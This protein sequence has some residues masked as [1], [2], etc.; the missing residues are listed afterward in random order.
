MHKTSHVYIFFWETKLYDV[1][2]KYVINDFMTVYDANMVKKKLY[3]WGETK[4]YDVVGKY[5]IN[6]FMTVYDANIVKKF[7][8][9][10]WFISVVT[11]II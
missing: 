7:D 3:F 2:G 4:L 11:V 8:E 10:L 9:N 1:I 6:D 5:V